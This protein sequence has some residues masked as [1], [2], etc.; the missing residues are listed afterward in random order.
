MRGT[1]A[2]VAAIVVAVAFSASGH[3]A[4]GSSPP[5]ACDLAKTLSRSAVRPVW[6]P[7]PQPAG[8]ALQVNADALPFFVRGLKW[9]AGARYFWLTRVPGGA[10]LGDL[11]AQQVAAA[12]LGN[13]GGRVRVLRLSGDGRLFAQWPTA[14][15]YPD[16]TA[17]VARGESLQR[18]LGFLV[19]LRRIGWPAACPKGG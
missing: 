13:L 6:F 12:Y 1:V 10:N 18:F 3:G 4:R 15:R 2:L 19:S 8:Y 14:G 7:S 5:L 9:S 11:A 17:L 16:T